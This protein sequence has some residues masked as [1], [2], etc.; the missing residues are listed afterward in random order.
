MQ[1]RELRSPKKVHTQSA[2]FYNALERANGDGLV[3]M[4]RD[5]H[6]ATMRMPPFLVAPLLSDLGETVPTK[7]ADH[8]LCCA[9][10]KSFT[11]GSATSSTLAPVGMGSVDGSNQSS[12]ASLAFV[13]ASSSVSPADAQPGSSGKNAAQ[14]STVASY[15]T[16]SRSF[17]SIKLRQ[18]LSSGNPGLRPD[19]ARRMARSQ[20]RACPAEAPRRRG[21]GGGARAVASR[22][23]GTGGRLTSRRPEAR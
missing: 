22:A 17:M 19:G 10:W 20:R 3:A 18:P 4:H 23:C 16:T 14:R 11:Q 15:S 5:D 7:N 21:E 6:L 9:Y 8:V 13:T 2:P 1:H 12:S